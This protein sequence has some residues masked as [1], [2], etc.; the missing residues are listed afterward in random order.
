MIAKLGLVF[1]V[2]ALWSSEGSAI[3]S[4]P[5]AEPGSTPSPEEVKKTL[6]ALGDLIAK[7]QALLGKLLGPG[8]PLAGVGKVLPGDLGKGLPGDLGK[9]LPGDLG[10][11]IPGDLGQGLPGGLLG[12]GR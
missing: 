9:G 2:V 12:G 5:P 6:G 11:G 3:P 10:K 7:I 8:G 4:P 1:V